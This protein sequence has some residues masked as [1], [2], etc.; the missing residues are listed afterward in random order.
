[1]VQNYLFILN[2]KIIFF[3]LTLINISA[4]NLLNFK[5]TLINI[6]ASYDKTDNFFYYQNITIFLVFTNFSI[7]KDK[8]LKFSD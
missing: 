8:L 1:M 4:S 5:L 6:S 7:Y 3:N 2:S